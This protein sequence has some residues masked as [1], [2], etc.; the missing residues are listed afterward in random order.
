[1]S[2]RDGGREPGHRPCGR[3]PFFRFEIAAAIYGQNEIAVA[4]ELLHRDGVGAGAVFFVPAV[5]HVIPGI[6]PEA[7]EPG[8]EECDGAC[9]VDVIAPENGDALV[10]A[11][12]LHE[13][14]CAG[15]MSFMQKGS[16]VSFRRSWS[17]YWG[18]SST[19]IPRMARTQA[20]RFG[21]L[22]RSAISAAQRSAAS[23][24]SFQ[25]RPVADRVIPRS[26]PVSVN[27][28]VARSRHAS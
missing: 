24:G 27:R 14:S 4:T 18:T 17:R 11:D 20:R 13:T 12:G 15:S 23:S 8:D 26:A 28:C 22:W 16:G 9:P 1:M 2:G 10:L 3:Q 19:P 21:S 5:R 25:H 7:A 6:L